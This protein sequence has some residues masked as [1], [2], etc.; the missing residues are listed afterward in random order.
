MRKVTY[1]LY[2]LGAIIVL[3]GIFM[4]AGMGTVKNLRVGDV[5][6]SRV[7]DGTYQGQYK[8]ARW[9]YTVNVTV[10]NH[11]I[12]GIEYA[13]SRAANQLM[14]KATDD[15]AARVIA[16]GSTKVD[17]VSGAT[18]TSKAFL[19]AIENALASTPK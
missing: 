18:V 12:T 15:L 10:K 14:S 6:L 16:Q 8:H 11:K 19:K 4:F 3:A 2:A 17:A 7:A 1:V 9:N 5:D 13:E